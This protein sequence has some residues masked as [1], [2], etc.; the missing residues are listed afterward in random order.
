MECSA[1]HSVILDLNLRCWT[2]QEKNQRKS[3]FGKSQRCGT[4]V[5]IQKI[6]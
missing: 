5:N 4:H 3:L 2:P 6:M 1:G